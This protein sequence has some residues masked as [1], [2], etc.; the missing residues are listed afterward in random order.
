MRER[1]PAAASGARPSAVSAR[2]PGRRARRRACTCTSIP[3]IWP[4]RADGSWK[5]LASRADAPGGL[6]YA[7]ENRIVVSQ[8]FPELF[9]DL[10]VQRLGVVLP[11]T[12]AKRS[13][14]WPAARAAAVLLTPG[15]YNEAY[16]EHAYLAHYLGLELVEGDDLAV[17]DGQVFLRTLAGL[18]RVAVIFRRVDSDFCDPLEF[19]GDS[20]LGV[21]GLVEVVRAGGVVLANALGGGVVESPAMDAYLPEHLARAASAKSCS[22]PDIPTIWCGTEWGRKEALARVRRGILRDAFDARPLFSRGSSARLG[23]DLEERGARPARRATSNG[24]ARPW[25]CRTSSPLGRRADVRAGRVRRRARMSLRVFA[26]WT[27]NGYV[28]MPGGLARV[29]ADDT[30]RA[31]SMQS[32][33]A[34]K[35]VWVLARGPVDTFSLLRPPSARV[36]IRRAGNEAPSRAMDNLFWLGRYAERTENL[37]RILRAVV[38]RLAGDPEFSASTNAVDLAQRLLVPSST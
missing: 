37:M 17:R 9:G 32:G 36:E 12:I 15:P 23:G 38:L 3:P 18:E 1:R 8:T 7:L 11:R 19:R 25:W 29:A 16:F 2:A 22:I 24:A 13:S 31:L 33:A 21:P 34:S 27:P 35:D 20:A 28:V 26:A 30:V 14:A 4:A 5:V 6:G 10:G